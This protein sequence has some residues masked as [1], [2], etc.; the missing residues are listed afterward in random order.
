MENINELFDELVT[1]PEIKE[2]SYEQAQYQLMRVECFSC[3][4][5]F[6]FDRDS[7]AYRKEG[8]L[9]FLCSLCHSDHR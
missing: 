5:M 6:D 9:F 2:I 1:E 8:E 4:C 3:V 7:K